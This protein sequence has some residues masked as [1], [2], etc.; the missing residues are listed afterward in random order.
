[1]EQTNGA[2]GELEPPFAAHLQCSKADRIDGREGADS[3]AVLQESGTDLPAL[4]ELLDAGCDPN[5]AHPNYWNTLLYNACFMDRADIV[6]LL[7]ARA[8]DPNRRMTYRSPVDGRVEEGPVALMLARSSE[9]AAALLS[10][11]ADP[12]APDSA[13]RT[14]LMRAVLGASADFVEQLL[15]AGAEPTVRS[16]AGHTAVDIVNDR[17]QWLRDSMPSLNGLKPT[18]DRRSWSTFSAS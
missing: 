10:A 11:G 13:G 3:V 15:A 17:L 4:E 1:M 7:L 14:P 2:L 8:A 9:V 12:N 16:N 6:K 5:T 18:R